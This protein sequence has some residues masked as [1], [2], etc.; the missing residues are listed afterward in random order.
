MIAL[1]YY[2]LLYS[3]IRDNKEAQ[4]LLLLFF[5]IVFLPCKKR[6]DTYPEKKDTIR[7]PCTEYKFFIYKLF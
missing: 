5:F 2:P 4:E 7:I 3:Q 6:K 1:F